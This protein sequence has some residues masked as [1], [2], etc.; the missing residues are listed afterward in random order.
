M[1]EPAAAAAAAAAVAVDAA[2]AVF[3][4]LPV[5]LPPFFAGA[6]AEFGSARL[7]DVGRPPDASSAAGCT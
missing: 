4:L 6:S 3:I 5:L 2:A 7:A 1:N